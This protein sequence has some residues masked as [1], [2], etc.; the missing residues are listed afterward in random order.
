MTVA[1]TN[2]CGRS[3][4]SMYLG[5]IQNVTNKGINAIT[6]IDHVGA[7]NCFHAYQLHSNTINETAGTSATM[8]FG[9]AL[10]FALQGGSLGAA[11]D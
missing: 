7:F 6:T 8:V 11:V 10:L 9:V 5:I 1:T 4:L 3:R 2:A